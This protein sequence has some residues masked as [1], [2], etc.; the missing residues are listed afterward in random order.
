MDPTD[1]DA[2]LIKARDE[3]RRRLRREL[4]DGLGP[5]LAAMSLRIDVA[6]RQ[7][8]RDPDAVERQLVALR[9]ESR[10]AIADIR[11]IADGLRPRRSTSSG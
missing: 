11:R 2:L 10:R 1:Q 6:L 8:A 3:E 7:L 5:T 9:E 4:H